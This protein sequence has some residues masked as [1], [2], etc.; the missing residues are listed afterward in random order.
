MLIFHLQAGKQLIDSCPC[1]SQV[2][3]VSIDNMYVHWEALL[4]ELHKQM[5]SLEESHRGKFAHSTVFRSIL[6]K[7]FL[8]NLK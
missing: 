1:V 5:L 2:V 3:S 4:K 6:T 8:T 7:T